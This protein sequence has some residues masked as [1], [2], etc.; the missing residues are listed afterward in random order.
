MAY[1]SQPMSLGEACYAYRKAHALSRAAMAKLCGVH[2]NTIYHCEL[3]RKLWASKE[4]K[5]ERIVF[6]KE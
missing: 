3:G 5:I 1:E 4:G 6:G 2:Y